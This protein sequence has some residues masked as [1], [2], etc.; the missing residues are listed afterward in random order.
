MDKKRTVRDFNHRINPLHEE[1]RI[2]LIKSIAMDLRVDVGE[3]TYLNDIKIDFL[4]ELS[5][6]EFFDKLE[7]LVEVLE[8]LDPYLMEVIVDDLSNREDF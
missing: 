8:K 6:Y 3:N 7:I 2:R 5:Q 1:E 4:N